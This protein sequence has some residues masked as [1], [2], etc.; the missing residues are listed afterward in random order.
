MDKSAENVADYISRLA[1]SDVKDRETAAYALFRLGCALAEPALRKWF[2][3]PEFRAL[4]PGGSS[5]LTVGVAVQPAKFEAIRARFGQPAL[6]EVPPNQDV[7]EFELAFAHGVRLDVMTPRTADKEGAIAKFLARFGE[8]IQQV[9]CEVRDVA[10]AAE[11]V[12]RRFQL[13]PIYP[14]IRAGANQ[15]QVNFFLV[16]VAEDRKLLIELVQS[17]KKSKSSKNPKTC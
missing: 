11:I 2:A 4:A 9:E 1:A 3:D 7:L 16:P 8:G 17:P 12:R 14:Q 13:E 6:A 5:L 15:T 10:R